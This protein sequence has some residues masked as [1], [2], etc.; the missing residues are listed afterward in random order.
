MESILDGILQALQDI[1]DELRALNT[2]L[3]QNV[4][5]KVTDDLV[6]QIKHHV[7][8]DKPSESLE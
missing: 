7:D 8:C 5:Q 4:T 2:K 1:A 3:N 6:D